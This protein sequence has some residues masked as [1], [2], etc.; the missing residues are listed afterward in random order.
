L[1]V[2][3]LEGAVVAPAQR[4]RQA[5]GTVLVEVEP[6]GLLAGVSLRRGM[7]IVASHPDEP[8]PVGTAKLDLDAAVALAQDTGGRLPLG[9]ARGGLL[10]H[11]LVH[12]G[13]GIRFGCLMQPY[14]PGIVGPWGGSA[15]PR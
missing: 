6:Q 12:I 3:L 11:V 10:G 7:R 4:L 5:V 14:S 15:L 8:P 9:L 1:P 2:N 13:R